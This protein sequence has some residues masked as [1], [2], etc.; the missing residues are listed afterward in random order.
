M[1]L[2]ISIPR[3]AEERL[4]EIARASG[5]DLSTYVSRLLEE[6]ATKST[7]QE[8]LA[9][10][11]KEFAE[12]GTSDEQWVDEITAAQSAYRAEQRQGK[13]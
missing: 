6:T 2:T 12:S 13:A 7:L 11:R 5:T 10:L 3:A 9:P 8:M 4:R 1:T